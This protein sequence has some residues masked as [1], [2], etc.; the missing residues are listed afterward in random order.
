MRRITR[1]PSSSITRKSYMIVKQETHAF[2]RQYFRDSSN[3]KSEARRKGRLSRDRTVSEC[4]DCPGKRVSNAG[5]KED[6]FDSNN[7][8][9]THVMASCDASCL[10]FESF[11][12]CLCEHEYCIKVCSSCNLKKPSLVLSGKAET[13]WDI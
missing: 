9:T 11:M 10:S 12:S 13:T 5:N 7:T 4:H 8:I 1:I 3:F 6:P 2:F